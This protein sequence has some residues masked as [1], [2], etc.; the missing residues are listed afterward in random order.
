MTKIGIALS[1]ITIITIA[2]PLLA[3]LYQY[4]NDLT[5]LVVPQQGTGYFLS[6]IT[7]QAPSFEYKGYK[8]INPGQSVSLIFSISN[9]SE[10]SVIISSVSAALYC[11][12]H[13]TFIGWVQGENTPIEIPQR[14][15]SV[16]RLTLLFTPE[17]KTDIETYH[18]GHNDLYLDLKGV[19][20][21]IQG[22]TINYQEFGE[23]GPVE[24]PIS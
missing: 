14:A 16:L 6:S 7:R 15:S 12:E 20:I 2:S 8:V 18:A 10:A 9:P 3:A 4:R 23:I 1:L 19:E 5:S 17:G 24:I 11:H 22:M 13:G 21:G